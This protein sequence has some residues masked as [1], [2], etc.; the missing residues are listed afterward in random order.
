MF[1]FSSGISE[2]KELRELWAAENKVLFGVRMRGCCCGPLRTVLCRVRD[3]SM[4]L[5]SLAALA[6]LQALE[7]LHVRDN[8]IKARFIVSTMTL[9]LHTVCVCV[10]ARATASGRAAR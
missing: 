5:S 4:Q 7:R 8:R 9:R 1:V 6:G 2:L 10:C 3:A